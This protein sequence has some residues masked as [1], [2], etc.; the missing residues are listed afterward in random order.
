MWAYIARRTLLTVPIVIGIVIITMILFTVLAKDPARM[1]A[2]RNA[3]PQVIESIRARMGLN[4]PKWF[5]AGALTRGD[6]KKAFDTQFFDVLLFRFPDSMRYEESIWGIIKKKGPVSLAIQVPAFVIATALELSLALW[7][8]SR[9]GRWLDYFITFASILLLSMPPLS[10]YI[11]AQWLFGQKLGIFPVA[12]WDA[13][14]YAVH[15][16]ALPIL[17][18]VIV[19]AGRGTRLYRTVVLDEIYSDY[20][21]TARAKGV[22]NQEILFTH[23]L[24]N[25]MIPVITNTV[26]ALPALLL[27]ALLLERIF[28]IPGLGGLLVEAIFNN[29]RPV[30]MGL[31]YVLAILYC[32][33]QLVSDVLYTVV[34]P[35]VVLK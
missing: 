26:T 5:D 32:V 6:V 8:A 35:Q 25:V 13:G 22:S 1:Y 20:V 4:K 24:R 18:M 14:A 7:A 2:G 15:F 30:L 3:S 34:N 16:A 9:R 23:V 11:L 33:L 10:L 17:M 12:G 27:G 19:T 28:Q 31:T 21:R 29:D